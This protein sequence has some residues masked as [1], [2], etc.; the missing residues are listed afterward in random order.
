MLPELVSA[1]ASLLGQNQANSANSDQ[2]KKNRQFQERMSNTAYQRQVADMRA[3]GINPMLAAKIGGASS[4][5]GNIPAPMQNS[6]QA[7][8]QAGLAAFTARK[9]AELTAASA[10]KVKAEAA[11]LK[12]DAVIA[13]K[14]ADL[15]EKGLDKVDDILKSTSTSAKETWKIMGEPD[16][17]K[18]A[19][20]FYKNK[21]RG[22]T[23]PFFDLF[24]FDRPFENKGHYKLKHK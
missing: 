5:V 20:E 24:D 14:K 3:A 21:A 13:D 16:Y 9:Q 2:A 8:V 18:N 22:L 6:A 4:P 11:K 17:L 12:P 7:G 10:E 1:G 15:L 23:K 19:F